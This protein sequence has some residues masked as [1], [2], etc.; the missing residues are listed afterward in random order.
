MPPLNAVVIGAGGR[1]SVYGNYAL[2][3]PRDLSVVAV[4]EPDD[5][6]RQ[7]FAGMH[8]LPP[9]ACFHTWQELIAGEKQADVLINC[10]MDQMHTESTLAA[11][12]A[13]YNV[14]LEK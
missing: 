6:R 2:N 9:E 8:D 10:T 7:R 5:M 13:G 3:Y 14:L 12:E 11:L 1:G 4:A